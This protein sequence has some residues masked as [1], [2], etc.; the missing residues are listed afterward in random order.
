[1]SRHANRR[2]FLKSSALTGAGLWVAGSCA[3]AQN[4]SPNEKLNMGIIGVHSRGAANMKAVASE[5]IVALC[6]VDERYLAEAAKRYPK[7][8]TYIDWRKMLEQK[9]VDAV[10]VSTTEHTHAPASVMAM[11]RGKHVFCEKPLAHS[12]YEARVMRETYRQTKVATQM[13][14]QIHATENYRRVVELVQSGAI[15]PVR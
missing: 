1:M 5:N 9:D 6:D 11:K 4:R 13:G 14:T 12:V 15:G 2:E 10:T 7:A 8:K 3:T